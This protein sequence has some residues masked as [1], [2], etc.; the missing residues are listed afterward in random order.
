MTEGRKGED[1]PPFRPSLAVEGQQ[2]AG[3]SLL[4][5]YANLVRLP[6]TV[7]ALPF[8]LLGV[9]AASRDYYVTWRIVGL[10]VV[11]FTAVRFVAMGFNRIVDRQLDRANPRTQRRE[12]PSGRLSTAQAVAAVVVAAAVFV[13]AC[14]QL[15]A[16]CFA[17]APVA[18][19]WVMTYS[20]TKRF[21]DWSHLWLGFS[22]AMAP[23]GGY[24]AVTGQWSDPGWLLLVLAAAVM[25]WVAGFDV[26][27]ALQDEAFDRASGLHSAVVRW[28]QRRSI[29]FAKGLHG[30]AIAGLVAFG[31]G[32]HVGL[33]YYVGVAVGAAVLVW[34]HQLVKPGDLSRLNA[35]FFNANGI[36][37]VVVFVGALLDRIA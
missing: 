13:W 4:V 19:A 24:I 20:F 23:A 34:E 11:A 16:L 31:W 15:N 10:V 37:S 32:A 2:L 8:A 36:V 3:E 6:H 35:A 12:L 7:F 18:L 30:L 17:L 28:G 25:F 5:R 22:L 26:F 9:I 29:L 27:Y 21:T 14:Y 1:I 33:W